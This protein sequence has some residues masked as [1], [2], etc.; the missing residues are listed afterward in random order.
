MKNGVKNS[1]KHFSIKSVR[2]YLLFAL[3]I[4]CQGCIGTTLFEEEKDQHFRE[5]GTLHSVPDRPEMP[6]MKAY[7]NLRRELQQEYQQ[8]TTGAPLLQQ[9]QNKDRSHKKGR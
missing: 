8:G 5:F 7:D 4:G 3:V 2:L 6:D 9:N 1:V